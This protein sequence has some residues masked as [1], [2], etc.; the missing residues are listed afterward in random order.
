MR[1]PSGFL[2]GCPLSWAAPEPVTHWFR[3]KLAV[4]QWTCFGLN[5][6]SQFSS[7]AE[8]IN[9]MNGRVHLAVGGLKVGCA[10]RTIVEG[11]ICWIVVV[12]HAAHTIEAR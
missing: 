8:A 2:L 10:R 5:A 12:W 7:A 3:H 4:L 6:S 11:C 9:C 1:R